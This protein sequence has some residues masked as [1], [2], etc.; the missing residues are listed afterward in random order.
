M[1]FSGKM[2]ALFIFMLL[3]PFA[4][5]FLFQFYS[6]ILQYLYQNAQS[7]CHLYCGKLWKWK[8]TK[9]SCSKCLQI[10]VILWKIHLVI[11][12]ESLRKNDPYF[13]NMIIIEQPYLSKWDKAYSVCCCCC[14]CYS[15]IHNLLSKV[16][17]QLTIQAFPKLL[18]Q[19]WKHMIV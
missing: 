17:I 5:G 19:S 1:E 3:C 11:L 9:I 14:Y 7:S 16:C 4:W 15:C 18:H 8:Y 10:P 6:I 13:I 2:C 12:N